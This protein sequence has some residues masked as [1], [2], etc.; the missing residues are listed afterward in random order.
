MFKIK[1]AYIYLYLRWKYSHIHRISEYLVMKFISF[2]LLTAVIYTIKFSFFFCYKIIFRNSKDNNKDK[3]NLN[4][5]NHLPFPGDKSVLP[6]VQIL[7]IILSGY[8][9]SGFPERSPYLW[10]VFRANGRWARNSLVEISLKKIPEC[11]KIGLGPKHSIVTSERS[12][13]VRFICVP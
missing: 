6:I 9:D 8:I 12:E 3:L 13:R 1:N 7:F 2:S 11:K 4:C 5:R 10:R